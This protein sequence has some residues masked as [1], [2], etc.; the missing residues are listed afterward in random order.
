MFMLD[1]PD[2]KSADEIIIWRRGGK[3]AIVLDW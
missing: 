3:P 1:P 2:A